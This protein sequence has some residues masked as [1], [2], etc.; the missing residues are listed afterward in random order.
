MSLPE[1]WN[2]DMVVGTGALLPQLGTLF[3]LQDMRLCHFCLRGTLQ[4]SMFA[5]LTNLIMF[6][7]GQLQ[8]VAGADDA[9]SDDCGIS[10]TLPTIKL[11][12]DMMKP[13]QS[14]ILACVFFSLHD[15]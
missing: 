4:A 9:I 7:A 11:R 1:L 6:D 5:G 13:W 12:W 15:H 2:L 14:S 3:Q 8:K 10:G